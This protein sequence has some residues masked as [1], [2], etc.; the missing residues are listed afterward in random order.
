MVDSRN[1]AVLTT[2]DMPTDLVAA[3]GRPHDVF[4]AGN[5]AFVTMLGVDGDTGVVIQYST[6]TF[7]ETGRVSVG[8]D[9][10]VFVRRGRL[11]V[12]SQDSSTIARF[13]ANNLR[14]AGSATVPAAH[15]LFVTNRNEV[16]VTNIAAAGV[17]AVYE[18]DSGLNRVRDTVDTAFPVPHT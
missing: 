1:L 7:E 17:D 9:P 3:G 12:A 13:T 18:L 4:V 8:D 6:R 5:R 14:P 10:H 11:Y 16:L 15:G 2:I